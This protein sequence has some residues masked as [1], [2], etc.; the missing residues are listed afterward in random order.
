MAVAPPAHVQSDGGK[1]VGE[2]ITSLFMTGL[3]NHVP[4]IAYSIYGLTDQEFECSHQLQRIAVA[5]RRTHV[6]CDLHSAGI[7]KNSF[8][9]I[10]DRV[11]GMVYL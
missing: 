9:T 11:L 6:H 10:V 3:I 8:I 1:K 2:R 7:H 5:D 4:G